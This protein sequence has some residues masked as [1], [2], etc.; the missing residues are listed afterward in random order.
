MNLTKE[1]SMSNLFQLITQV[2]AVFKNYPTEEESTTRSQ[3]T[4]MASQH[5][6]QFMCQKLRLNTNSFTLLEALRNY[7]SIIIICLGKDPVISNQSLEMLDLA[8]GQIQQILLQNI[9]PESEDWKKLHVIMPDL[10][11]Y[12]PTTG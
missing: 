10:D 9:P 4:A 3:F 5:F 6:I 8:V 2:S 7:D 1:P 12:T 11:K